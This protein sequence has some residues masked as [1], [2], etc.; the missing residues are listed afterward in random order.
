MKNKHF[1]AHLVET[2]DITVELANLNMSPEERIHL[3]SL[4]EAN[5]HSSIIDTVLSSLD[6]ENKKIFLQNLSSNNHEK[7]WVHLKNKSKNIEEDIIQ[8]IEKLKKEL[9]EDIRKVKPK[10]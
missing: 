4:I 2:T 1:Y 10:S 5:I 6:E 8:S 9:R 3:L 7:V